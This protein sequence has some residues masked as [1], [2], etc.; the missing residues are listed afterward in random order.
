MSLRNYLISAFVLCFVVEAAWAQCVYRQPWRARRSSHVS[1]VVQCEV[2]RPM[3][4]MVFDDFVCEE[5][6]FIERIR[7]WGTVS[8]PEQL[9]RTYVITFWRDDQECG[10]LER[11]YEACVRPTARL[12]GPDCTEERV[13]VFSTCIPPFLAIIGPHWVSIAED[14]ERSI[15]PNE[16]DF[17]W[18]G[19]REIRRCPAFSRDANGNRFPLFDNCD[20]ERNDVSFEM[21][22]RGDMNC[23]GVV[24]VGDINP[25]V[26]ALTNPAAYQAAFP[27]CDIFNGDCNCDGQIS[28]G[29]INC[30]VS[31]VT[32]P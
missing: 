19:R 12:V 13:Y 28:V 30:F 15:Q 23:D 18:S 11:V 10:T 26:L 31:L 27:G 4:R 5:D 8:D 24:S 2:P 17:R 16:V 21:L 29:D 32:G 22:L 25:F 14:D 1:A 20:E 9:N 6:G 7:W 3:P